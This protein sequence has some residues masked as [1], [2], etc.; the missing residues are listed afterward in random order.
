[1]LAIFGCCTHEEICSA[2]THLVREAHP[3]IA[4]RCGCSA[5]D[6]RRRDRHASDPYR[7]LRV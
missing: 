7:Q 6:R 3:F 2:A 4:G 5:H 1:M